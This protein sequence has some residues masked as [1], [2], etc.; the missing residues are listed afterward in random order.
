MKTGPPPST[1]TLVFCHLVACSE[2]L[3]AITRT[4]RPEAERE[5]AGFHTAA[6]RYKRRARRRL[7]G[8]CKE[9]IMETR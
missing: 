1:R 8:M 2:A 5:K 3:A 7:G 9:F 6:L 4:K